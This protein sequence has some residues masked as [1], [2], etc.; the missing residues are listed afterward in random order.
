MIT[1]R[2]SFPVIWK[3]SGKLGGL[4]R[5]R[6]PLIFAPRCFFCSLLCFWDFLDFLLHQVNILIAFNS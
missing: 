6:N 4:M 2:T 5:H 1:D 3:L